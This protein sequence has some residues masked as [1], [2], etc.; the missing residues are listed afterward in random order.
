[1]PA[2]MPEA[3]SVEW[4]TPMEIFKPLYDQYQFTLDVCARDIDAAMLPK[5]FTPEQ[6]GLAQDWTGERCWMNPPYGRGIDKWVAKARNHNVVALLPAR[7]DTKWFHEH[8]LP[9]GVITF[10]RGRVKFING[11]TGQPMAP[12]PF[13]CMIVRWDGEPFKPA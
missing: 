5:F 9:Y 7:T 6:D 1:M 2:Y 12:A 13:P 8:V 10:L 4:Y 3:K 11:E